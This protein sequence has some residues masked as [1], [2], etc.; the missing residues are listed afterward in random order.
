MLHKRKYDI[1][2]YSSDENQIKRQK[3]KVPTRRLKYDIY[4]PEDND[5]F[6]DDGNEIT[7]LD[8]STLSGLGHEINKQNP[9]SLEKDHDLKRGM[10]LDKYYAELNSVLSEKPEIIDVRLN[11][12]FT[13]LLTGKSGC[14]KTY[15]LVEFLRKWKELTDDSKGKLLKKILCFYGVEQPKEFDK[16]KTE[17]GSSHIEFIAGLD[18]KKL[19]EASDCII[20]LDDLMSN[21]KNDN[22]VAQLFTKSS[23]HKSVTVFILWQSPFPQGKITKEIATN[24]DYQVLFNN[25]R[26]SNHLRCL[27]QQMTATQEAGSELFKKILQYFDRN[28]NDYPY[29]FM[30]FKPGKERK[31]KCLINFLSNDEKKPCQEL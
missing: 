30:N 11:N 4:L 13:V 27:C 22:D 3:Y 26:Q 28:I 15:W 18:M 31:I 1:D 12:P 8:N 6:I 16:L 5:G 21:K 29:V 2:S 9:E 14:G 23:H 10:L 17:F 7:P 24:A 19:Q 20:I 25:E